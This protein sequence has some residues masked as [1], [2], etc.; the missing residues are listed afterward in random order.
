MPRRRKECQN[1]KGTKQNATTGQATQGS[2]ASLQKG[3][4]TPTGTVIVELS[5]GTEAS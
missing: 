4:L 2:N 1:S 3:K 5:L